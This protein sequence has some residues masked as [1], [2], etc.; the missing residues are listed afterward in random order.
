MDVK[1]TLKLLLSNKEDTFT[2]TGPCVCCGQPSQDV[3]K[4]TKEYSLE[5]WVAGSKGVTKQGYKDKEGQSARGKIELDLPYCSEHYD[6][7]KR[8]HNYHSIQNALAGILG[9]VAI[10]LYFVLFGWDW[11]G[12]AE[13]TRE[14]G[15]RLCG[16]PIFVGIGGFALGFLASKALNASIATLPALSDYPIDSAS[17]GGSGLA[18]TVDSET[19]GI[20]GQEVRHYLNL[21]F[22]NVE[23]AQ[24]FKQKHPGARVVKG[25]ELLQ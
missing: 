19:T 22:K 11:L 3:W 12:G 7:T 20:A 5:R 10:V 14:F 25:R 8:L 2:L 15:F 9:F 16:V 13:T 23:A 24:Q 18:I 17:G 4:Y 6:Q 21:D 1:V